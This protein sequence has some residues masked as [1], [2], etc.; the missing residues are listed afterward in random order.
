MGTTAEE[1]AT[2]EMWQR[3]T[4]NSLGNAVTTYFHHATDGLGEADRYR[5]KEWGER[6]RE[7]AIN[8]M[9]K[10]NDQLDQNVFIA[11]ETFS[12]ADITALCAIDFAI[13]VN[14]GIPEQCAHLRNWHDNVSN[15]ES[16]AA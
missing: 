12:I 5:N 4:E 7:L 16:A 2:I 10:L 9:I 15:R 14:I 3:R 6:N 11:G 8:A 13:A 1:K